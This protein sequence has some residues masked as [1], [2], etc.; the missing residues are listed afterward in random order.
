[1][2]EAKKRKAFQAEPG[3]H[4]LCACCGKDIN[5]DEGHYYCNGKV[6]EQVMRLH[7]DCNNPKEVP[8]PEVWSSLGAKP[9]RAPFKGDS[10]VEAI[11]K[12]KGQGQSQSQGEGEGEGNGE[13]TP[14]MWSQVPQLVKPIEEALDKVN[15]RVD[16]AGKAHT[17]VAEALKTLKTDVENVRKAGA[18]AQIQLVDRDNEVVKTLDTVHFK[19][20]E[21]LEYVMEGTHLYLYGDKG[22]GKSTIAK[23]VA[24]ALGRPF[25]YISLNALSSASLLTGFMNAQG[26]FVETEFRRI[27]ENGGVFCIDELDNAAANVLTALNGAIANEI[28]AFAD[29]NV[30]MHKDFILIGTGNTALRGATPEYPERRK[31]DESVMDRLAFI[32]VPYDK[33]LERKL[34]LQFNEN[35][36]PW[37]D[38][39]HN[40]RDYAAAPDSGIRSLFATPRACLFGAKALLNHNRTAASVA[41]TWVFKGI[42]PAMQEKILKAHK[43]PSDSAC[44]GKKKTTKAGKTAEAVIEVVHE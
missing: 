23:Q 44:R 12:A 43:L 3:E 27:Y 11:A 17:A 16:M 19:F 39:V 28:A 36:G 40:V 18:V 10:L 22:G 8:S 9:E 21:I 35:A 29:K 2:S 7:V 41:D 38:W 34:A 24:D 37:V 13:D 5:G 42:N 20:A 1:M 31:G 15:K 4:T 6:A 26:K 14:V 25:G 32:H 33:A 30:P